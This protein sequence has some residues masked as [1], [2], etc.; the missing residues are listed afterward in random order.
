[1][2]IKHGETYYFN[3]IEWVHKL[4]WLGGKRNI[5]PNHFSSQYTG[6]HW[7]RVEKQAGKSKYTKAF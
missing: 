7:Q 3:L 4:K 2:G 5:G 6:S 1:M